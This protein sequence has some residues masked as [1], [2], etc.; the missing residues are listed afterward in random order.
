MLR[1]LTKSILVFA[2]LLCPLLTSAGTV[3]ITVNFANGITTFAPGAH[4]T[5]NYVVA[6]NAGVIPAN[7]AL[8]LSTSQLPAWATQL[9]NVASACA[10][11]AV[12]PKPF[13]L[14]AGQSCCLMLDLD[15]TT[16]ASQAHGLSVLVATTPATYQARATTTVTVLN[17]TTQ[18]YVGTQSG[19]VYYSANN[20]ANWT[21]LTKPVAGYAVNGVTLSHNILYAASTDHHVYYSTNNGTSWYKS[22]V[23]PDA[24][25]VNT[26]FVTSANK[27][28]IGTDG[29]HVYSSTDNGATWTATMAAP[30]TGAVNGV[31]GT[32]AGDLYAGS[33]DGFVYYSHDSGK[34]WAAINGAPDGSAIQDVYIG[35]NTLYVNTANEYAYT[36]TNLKGG[37]A[38]TTYAQTVYRLFVDSKA[39][40]INAGTQGG[41]VY[42]LATGD[43][44]GF[45]TA[46][47]IN[48][49]FFK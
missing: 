16:L 45:V 40:I 4:G 14:K 37:G 30:G 32:D 9:T 22:S 36:S 3:P 28:L 18:D 24:S 46:S 17:T 49:L 1:N 23:T 33:A 31:F 7:T 21:A 20:G 5:A 48:G 44:L 10:G 8:N 27:I 34:N 12:C 26:V 25:A 6:V 11:I 43:E 47:P 42:S 19:S 39:A 15:G 41:Y 35:N 29:G 2:L 13:P 38:W